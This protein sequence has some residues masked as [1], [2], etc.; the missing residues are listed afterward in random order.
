MTKTITN[1]IKKTGFKEQKVSENSLYIIAGATGSLGK[2]YC[3]WINTNTNNDVLAIHRSGTINNIPNK[4]LDLLHKEKCYQTIKELNISQY[5]HIVYIHPVG[6]FKFE[7]EGPEKDTNK[8]SIDDFVFQSNV[9]TFTNITTPLS[10]KI[11]PD[12]KL[13]TVAFGSVSDKYNIPYW[14]SYTDSKNI[15]RDLIEKNSKRK[16]R[17]GIFVN[18]STVN[19]GNENKLRPNPTDK[20]HWL[21]AREIV[22]KSMPIIQN[23]PKYI[24]MDIYKE[25]PKYTNEFYTNKDSILSRWKKEMGFEE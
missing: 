11:N 15:L 17:T 3:D 22:E 6:T 19:T 18:V 25:S 5:E 13:I 8:D 10:K 12:Q 14:S 20:E 23:H 9:E 1:I 2:A 16:N 7:L 21:T 24:E 4:Q